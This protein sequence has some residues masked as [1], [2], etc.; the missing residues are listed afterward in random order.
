MLLKQP[1]HK[2]CTAYRCIK[3]PLKL[4]KAVVLMAVI[5]KKSRYLTLIYPIYFECVEKRYRLLSVYPCF[6]CAAVC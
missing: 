6:A 3:L 5:A 4:A 2:S 1:I